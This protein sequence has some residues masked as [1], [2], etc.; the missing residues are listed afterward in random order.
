[1]HLGP[2]LIHRLSIEASLKCSQW[3]DQEG[4]LKDRKWGEKVEVRQPKQE[5]EVWSHKSNFET[6]GSNHS[7]YVWMRCRTNCKTGWRL[8]HGLTGLHSAVGF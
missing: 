5:L 6:F 1:M 7:Q 4:V 8:C 2:Q 3:K